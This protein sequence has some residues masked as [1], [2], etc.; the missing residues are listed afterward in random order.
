M[1]SPHASDATAENVSPFYIPTA[2]S[3]TRLGRTLKH[4]DTFVVF[5]DSG[6]A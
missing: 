6:D 3:R 5:D 4:G 1:L 2:S